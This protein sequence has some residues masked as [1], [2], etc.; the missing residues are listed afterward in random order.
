MASTWK[1]RL[2]ED[3]AIPMV[4]CETGAVQLQTTSR[5][6]EEILESISTTGLIVPQKE[7]QKSL[8]KAAEILT[9]CI[10]DVAESVLG[11]RTITAPKARPSL[12]HIVPL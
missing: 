1:V 7:A 6:I 3:P 10:I 11:R 12:V 9:Q 5:K 8:D 2:L 4:Y